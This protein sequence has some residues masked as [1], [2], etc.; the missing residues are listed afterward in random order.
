MFAP[1]QILPHFSVHCPFLHQIKQVYVLPLTFTP[2]SFFPLLPQPLIPKL[3]IFL[4]ANTQSSTIL[5]SRC[6][7]H[8]K[9]PIPCQI[10][11]TLN[12]RKTVQ[13]FTSLSVPRWDTSHIHLTIIRSNY[14]DSQV[15]S[16]KFLSR[17]SVHSGNK[18]CISFPLI[19]IIFNINN[20]NNLLWWHCYMKRGM[21]TYKMQIET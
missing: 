19:I 5:C 21:F 12:P 13:I 1:Y 18:L 8:P 6:P 20:N 9:L 7:S 11:H 3:T 4:Q 2:K 17:R 15:P 14:A 10:S 16:F